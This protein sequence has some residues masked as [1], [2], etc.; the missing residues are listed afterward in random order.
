MTGYGA[1][2]LA[3]KEGTRFTSRQHERWKLTKP[4]NHYEPVN[5]IQQLQVHAQPENDLFD[6]NETQ[7]P[8]PESQ[9]MSD[10]SNHVIPNESSGNKWLF[11]HIMAFI[12]FASLF[13]CIIAIE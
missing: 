10:D 9:L 7:P 6:S 8:S 4:S 13:K 3:K 2:G 12:C 5:V 11:C 1:K